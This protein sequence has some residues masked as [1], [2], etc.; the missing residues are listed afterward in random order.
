MSFFPLPIFDYVISPI[1]LVVFSLLLWIQ[2]KRPLRHQRLSSVRRVARNV[3]VSVPM[4]IIFRLLM[5]PLP[6]FTAIWAASHDVGL[7]RWSIAR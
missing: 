7:L 6:L 2:W 5:V 4:F 3:G 1:M